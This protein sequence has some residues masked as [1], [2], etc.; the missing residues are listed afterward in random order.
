MAALLEDSKED[1]Q[2]CTSG[3][4][5]KIS[6]LGS[7]EPGSSSVSRVTREAKKYVRDADACLRYMDN[8]VRDQPPKVRRQLAPMLQTFRG[9]LANLKA[10]LERA[11]QAAERGSLLSGAD[12]MSKQTEDQRERARQAAR[13]MDRTTKRLED[14]RA[15]LAETEDI[16][17]G[18][19]TDL[20]TQRETLLRAHQKVKDTNQLTTR[21]RRLLRGIQGRACTNKLMLWVI[22]VVLLGLIGVVIYFGLFAPT[23]TKKV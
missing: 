12:R 20:H 21:A 8:Q 18:I 11:I 10:D 17:V 6:E 19:M 1:F 7:L 5:K 22:I 15:T 3:I 4:S 23:A 16:G 14:T 13:R 2:S 9:D